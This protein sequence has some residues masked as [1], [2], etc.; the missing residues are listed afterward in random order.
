M[1]EAALEG[2]DEFNLLQDQCCTEV[3]EFLWALLQHSINLPRGQIG[4][5]KE[6]HL[7]PILECEIERELSPTRLADNFQRL[8][9]HQ[10]DALEL[11]ER[12]VPDLIIYLH[13]VENNNQVEVRLNH[14][15]ILS[16]A[17]SEVGPS[18]GK[19]SRISL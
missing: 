9:I 13:S 8:Q 15:S 17:S 19:L 7:H 5:R 16:K 3:A 6:I 1:D 12:L 4:H 18:D 10:N 14:I 2:I 11:I